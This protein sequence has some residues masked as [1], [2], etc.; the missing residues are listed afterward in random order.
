MS[1]PLHPPDNFDA[2]P[3]D[4]PYSIQ[5]DLMRH[6]Y[7]SIEGKKVSVVESPT[8]TGK[9]LTLLCASLTWLSDDRLRSTR[10]AETRDASDWVAAQAQ[11]IKK[12]ELAD[13]EQEYQARLAE[14]RKHEAAL[15]KASSGRVRKRRRVLETV[16]ETLPDDSAF[17]PDD[18]DA[19]DPEDNISP[20]VRALMR[21]VEQSAN[22]KLEPVC[23]PTKIYYTSRTHSQLSQVLSELRKLKH[24]LMM[25]EQD[26]KS[27]SALPS[28]Q[29]SSRNVF[30][31]G[32]SILD[33]GSD[34]KT[35]SVTKTVSLGSRKYLCIND[36]VKKLHDIDEACRELLAD[37]SSRRCPHLPPSD[38]RI[39]MMDLRD[40][41]LASPKDIEDLVE[42]GQML[43]T[44]PYFG[45]R[46]AIPQAELVLLP[47][48]L[49]L[50]K[51]AR[52]ALNIDLANQIVIVDEA[53]NLIATLLSLAT[54]SLSFRTLS[55]SLD[56]LTVYFS[57]FRN[58][59]TPHHALHLK[60]LMTLLVALRSA[61]SSRSMSEKTKGVK[62]TTEVMT[63]GEFIR[64]LG[65]KVE[66]VNFAEIETYLRSSKI[67]R[68]ISGYADKMSQDAAKE[69][70]PRLSTAESY[71]HTPAV[72][73][74]PGRSGAVP[75]LYA[76]E[77]FLVALNNAS[78]DGRISI[79]GSKPEE[80]EIKYQ[81]LNPS[82][83]FADV[84]DAARCVLLAGGTM[85]PMSDFTNQ[86]FS[87]VPQDRIS[88]FS[89]G[90]V[91]PASNLQTLI[92]K[93][94]PAGGD[95]LF[96][97]D[98][99][100][101]ASV[102]AELGQIISNFANV[103]SG[104]MVVFFPSYSFLDQVKA[105]W[106]ES[107]LLDKIAAKKKIFYEPR[108]NAEVDT[109]L[110][111]YTKCIYEGET[112]AQVNGRKPGAF[113]FAVVGAK[114]SEGLNFSD[115]LARAVMVIGLPFANLNSPD[116]KE[117]LKYVKALQNKTGNTPGGKDAGTE[118]YENMCMNAV[119]QSIGRA[120]RHRGD[121][122]SLILVDSRYASPRIRQKLPKWIGETTY[123]CETFGQGMKEVGSFF[124][125]K[126]P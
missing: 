66:G 44:C 88:T 19:A 3:Y 47:Y 125:Q 12:R 54:I 15:R 14:M 13:R 32:V 22:T 91:I 6:V 110:Q 80:R 52:E 55:S 30:D 116:L 16:Q 98:Q 48:N 126:R 90:H 118:L 50:D 67:A 41:I 104:G 29:E 18:D 113:M 8:G 51:T 23:T 85:S 107:K 53:H 40:H 26:T 99:R 77:S 31:V 39:R 95:L 45:S 108:D 21:R 25:K 27:S 92:L 101:N 37:S 72:G 75:P 119:N 84:I 114:L 79:S 59:L 64:S 49:L 33:G 65:R 9:T 5:K 86:L 10:A 62:E 96:K 87:H 34:P 81:H 117:R 56:Q 111:Q 46:E 105:V 78:E 123:V 74:R 38:D 102:L 94:G 83:H 60:R 63:V 4:T 89:C 36:E 82:T 57:K 24:D 70:T 28:N 100:G 97:Y 106:T 43:G 42:I 76:V 71:E 35:A 1:L 2:F 11:Q 93:K 69:G 124:R 58:R 120:I 109:V 68:K 7:E 121:W 103:V 17:L 20:A 112:M 122:A 115:D 61:L 73:Q